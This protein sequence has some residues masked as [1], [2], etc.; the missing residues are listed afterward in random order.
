[1]LRGRYEIAIYTYRCGAG[2]QYVNRT[3]TIEDIF[4]S[5]QL[6]N[7]N[8]RPL[9]DFSVRHTYITIVVYWLYA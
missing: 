2:D 6:N 9:Y 7:K 4:C 8:H 5:K 1:M 3:L